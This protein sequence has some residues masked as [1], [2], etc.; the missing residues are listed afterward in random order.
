M[1]DPDIPVLRE[2]GVRLPVLAAPMAGGPST[3][4]LVTAA[5]NAGSLGFLA[6]GY[7]S[8]GDLE[9]Q[10]KSVA[11]GGAAFGVNLFVPNAVPVS[12]DDYRRYARAL[13]AEAAPYGIDL[14]TV[15][16]TED[17]DAW[18][19]KIDVVLAARPALVTTTFGIP[20]AGAVRAL[21]DAG[22]TVG[23]TVTSAAE[24]QRAAEANADLLV[25][26]AS[27]AGGHSGT[28]SPDRIPE[29]TDLAELVRSVRAVAALPVIAAGGIAT[30]D[31]VS[32]VLA[33]GAG[34]VAV[35]TV[36]LRTAES[37]AS[38]THRSALVDPAFDRT[39][40]TRS[41]TGRPAR[42]LANRWTETHEDEA[43]LGYPAIH[44]LTT[45]LRRAAAAAGD[46]HRVHLWAGTGWRAAR[47][48]PVAQSLRRL[49]GS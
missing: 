34:G 49:A 25:V 43:P 7:K 8:A 10:A 28:M 23:M 14:E 27:A 15:P 32:R 12:A 2:L 24:A 20:S 38:A 18:A 6:A 46:P 9:A 5:W 40:V 47:E 39:V 41:F 29:Q 3:P 37:G 22:I 42:G 31:D 21:Q 33:A 35:G 30:S 45:A 36:L 17:D 4:Q 26:Q 13:A 11:E 16:L 44:H 1:S 48:E 19:D